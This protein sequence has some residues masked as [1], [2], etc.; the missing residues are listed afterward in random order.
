MPNIEQIENKDNEALLQQ[1]GV[2]DENKKLDKEIDENKK[3]KKKPENVDTEKSGINPGKDINK[4]MV[5]TTNPEKTNGNYA[6]HKAFHTGKYGNTFL[7][8]DNLKRAQDFDESV[9]DKK[10]N[11]KE[12]IDTTEN[13]QKKLK[14]VE[15][16]ETKVQTETEGEV[17]KE[18]EIPT[19][20]N[21]IP[22]REIEHDQIDAVDTQHK[23]DVVALR[24][25]EKDIDNETVE[26]LNT[27]AA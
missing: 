15:K 21:P 16:E 27:F 20:E 5:D 22:E 3:N 11:V 12:A 2:D 17:P 25:E 8:E 24:Q 23:A 13:A 10:Q 26:K 1:E 18:E 6:E 19:P 4:D 14:Q 7:Y 9:N